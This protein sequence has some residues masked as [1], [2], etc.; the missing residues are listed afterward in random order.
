MR[1]LL[2]E[3]DKGLGEF[4]RQGLREAGHE[5][6]WEADGE[7]GL[8]EALATRHD[9]VLLDVMLPGIGGLDVLAE[10]RRRDVK[11]PVLLLTA[12]DGVDDRVRGLDQGPTTTSPSRS[13]SAS[14]SLV[15]APCRVVHPSR[16]NRCYVWATWSSISCATTCAGANA[17]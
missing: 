12:L 6:D 17:A 16:R 5:V 1:L 9:L 3:D 14:F 7:R 4:V 2:I 10:M 8:R 11:T 15:S 13:L